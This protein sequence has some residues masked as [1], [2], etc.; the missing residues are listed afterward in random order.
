[1][2]T[3]SDRYCILVLPVVVIVLATSKSGLLGGISI[4]VSSCG[5]GFGGEYICRRGVGLYASK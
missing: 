2:G 4:V 1:M 5:D 3:F